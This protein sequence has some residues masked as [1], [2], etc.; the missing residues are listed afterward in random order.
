MLQK[1]YV[2]FRRKLCQRAKKFSA[3]QERKSRFRKGFMEHT[4][5][6][7]PSQENYQII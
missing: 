1:S 7:I 3:L 6:Y 5:S 2:L 4:I